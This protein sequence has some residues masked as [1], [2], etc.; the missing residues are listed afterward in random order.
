MTIPTSGLLTVF[1]QC[2]ERAILTQPIGPEARFPPY[3]FWYHVA[4]AAALLPR[5]EAG[6]RPAPE[7][8][9][10]NEARRAGRP[11]QLE[12]LVNRRSDEQ[13]WNDAG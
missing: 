4:P 10:E 9:Q 12:H 5:R 1:L 11:S 8:L 6:Y 13:R 2:S 3:A 7:P